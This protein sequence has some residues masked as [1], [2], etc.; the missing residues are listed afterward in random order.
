MVLAKRFL[1]SVKVKIGLRFIERHL[2]YVVSFPLFLLSAVFWSPSYGYIFTVFHFHG[3]LLVSFSFIHYLLAVLFS[4]VA[5]GRFSSV[6]C[7]VRALL[8]GFQLWVII[9]HLVEVVSVGEGIRI[10]MMQA[11]HI[12]AHKGMCSLF[13]LGFFSSLEGRIG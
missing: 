2:R 13:T 10:M 4:L 9:T 5:V 8:G 3:L 11:V 7:Q 1:L 6:C 12:L